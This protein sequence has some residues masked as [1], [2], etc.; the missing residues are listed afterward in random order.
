ME[1]LLLAGYYCRPT[2]G[3]TE[4]A[5]RK[6]YGEDF[7][8]SI[9]RIERFSACAFAHFLTYGLCLKER[10]EYEFRAVDIGNVCHSALEIF[11]RKVKKEGFL[12]TTLSE[13]QRNIFIEE[14]VEEAI[15]DYGNSVLYSS[16][17]NE[18]MIVRMKRMLARTVWALTEQLKAGDFVPSAYELRFGNGKIDRID[19]CEDGDCLYVKVLDY[20]T[21]GTAF[22]VVALYHGLQL[23]L[24][25]YMDAALKE[26]EKEHPEKEVIPAGVFYY[27]IQDPLVDKKEDELDISRT[28][29]KELK[30][31]GIVNLKE[32]ALAH[33]DR[34]REG[35]S[36]AAPV[37]F[38]KN[39]SLSKTS[40]A[41]PEEE[42][43]AMMRHAVKKVRKAHERIL[44][45]ETDALPYRRGQESGCD[46]CQ[47]RHVCGFDGKV[48][49]FQYRDIGKMSREEAIAAMKREEE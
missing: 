7:E 20:K 5:A 39:G 40:K 27:R 25:V 3:L 34:Q 2:D 17:R 11:S 15:A 18:Y 14:S 23:Q 33:L 19:T 22:D 4:A 32:R 1:N 49:G 28:I 36:L 9:T 46:Y 30:P 24:M 21:G 13:E 29:L 35:E 45:G 43:Q 37:K 6:L 8:D 10:Q 44:K 38:N 48:P 31:D 26:Q 42:F 41:V 47:Y 12:W 16:A